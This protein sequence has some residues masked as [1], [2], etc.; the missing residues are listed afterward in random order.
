MWFSVCIIRAGH[1]V[2]LPF[3]TCSTQRG[4]FLC[5]VCSHI[6]QRTVGFKCQ[7]TVCR[8]RGVFCLQHIE[9]CIRIYWPNVYQM[10]LDIFEISTK[11]PKATH[12][13]AEKSTKNL[14]CLHLDPIGEK[15]LQPF[16]SESSSS[17]K[18]STRPLVCCDF[19]GQGPALFTHELTWT[20]H[21]HMTK[22][23]AG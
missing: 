5:Q 21:R 20:V 11:E 3:H 13:Q 9:D 22:E 23:L 8:R 4:A 17:G 6:K 2:A 1:C 18:T 10:Y 14:Q 15:E 16:G 19:P 12:R 7:R